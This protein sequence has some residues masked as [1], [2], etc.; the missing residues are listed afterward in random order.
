MS[1]VLITGNLGY[2]GVWV[3]H[4]L[5]R[6]GHR[7]VGLDC[8]YYESS[9]YESDDFAA[10]YQILKD[11]RDLEEADLEGIDVVVHLAALSNDAMGELN[12]GLTVQ[13]NKDATVR[14]AR[15]ARQQ[16]VQ[17]FVYVSLCDIYGISDSE[18]AVTEE[19]PV[20]PLT[21]Y[22]QAKVAA[23]SEL[24]RLHE[25]GFRVI[26]MRNATMHGVS[27]KLRLDLVLNN[28][29]ASACLY[30]QVKISGDGSC[31]RPLLSSVDFAR[32]VLLFLDYDVPHL[33]Y[34]VGVSKENYQVRTL[35]EMISTSTGARLEIDPGR[36]TEERSCRMD[37]SRFQREF[38]EFKIR[39]SAR[40][41][42]VGLLAAYERYGLTPEDFTGPKY[43]RIRALKDLITRGVL[44]GNLARTG[45]HELCR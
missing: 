45:C 9:L 33:V 26:I 42:I 8:D 29:A 39:M 21:V 27:P 40:E 6:A 17:K 4:I 1:R 5:K 3:T 20:M 15:L 14:L 25:D 7:T 36:R 31:W 10:D 16:G 24:I 13:I 37:F 11:L 19:A 41:S 2:S 23:E 35:G 44:D 18:S 30:G 28:L 12:P 32:A 22:A 34:N 38:P 43:F